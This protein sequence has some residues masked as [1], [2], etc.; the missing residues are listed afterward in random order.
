MKYLFSCA[1]IAYSCTVF[2]N[3][4]TTPPTAAT[5]TTTF[6][7]ILSWRSTTNL[8]YQLSP[9]GNQEDQVAQYVNQEKVQLNQQEEQFNQ[10]GHTDLTPEPEP[11]T[12]TKP[13]TEN[14]T[15]SEVD[16]QEYATWS[17]RSW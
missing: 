13:T 10:W 11:A 15:P 3:P 14:M 1:L 16:T 5:P 9:R 7:R 8:P 6:A 17:F 2:A 12:K 4:Q